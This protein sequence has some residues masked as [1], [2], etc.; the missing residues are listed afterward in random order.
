M[1]AIGDVANRYNFT[2]V[3][4][5][6]GMSIA[7]FLFGNHERKVKYNNIPSCI[8]SLPNFATVGL[9]EEEARTQFKKIEVYKS[10]FTPLKHTLTDVT[11]RALMK[12]IVDVD[13][14]RI[15]GAHMVGQDA[16]EI[17]QGLAVAMTAGATKAHFDS[18]IGIHPTAAEE[19]VT[20]RSPSL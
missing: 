9:S 13:T 17:I 5:A 8:F 19:F 16:G 18:T 15:L 4:I 14:S 11:E 10:E 3:A 7:H 2:P 12:L 6:E 1:F 20:M